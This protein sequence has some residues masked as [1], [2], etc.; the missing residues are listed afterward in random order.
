[1]LLFHGKLKSRV[2]K[3]L[4]KQPL[5]KKVKQQKKTLNLNK[6]DET[7]LMETKKKIE[8]KSKY[9]IFIEK[10]QRDLPSFTMKTAL[11][12]RLPIS[13]EKKKNRTDKKNR[14]RLN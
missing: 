7:K 13:T 6:E 12:K 1:M 9:K 11:T 14:I 8:Q 4:K 3:T 2:K 10:Y 5:Q